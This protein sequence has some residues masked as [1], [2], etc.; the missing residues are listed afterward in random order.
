MQQLKHN[1]NGLIGGYR[2]N[3]I[4][5]DTNKPSKDTSTTNTYVVLS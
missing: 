1:P 3:H 5:E 4:T 2:E